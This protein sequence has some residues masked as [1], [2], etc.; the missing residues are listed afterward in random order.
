MSEQPIPDSPQPAPPESPFQ[1]SAIAQPSPTKP[2]LAEDLKRGWDWIV[3]AW[4]TL[5]RLGGPLEILTAFSTVVSILVKR[6]LVQWG[7][8]R[9][10]DDRL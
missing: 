8:V 6:T 9:D 7:W 3:F 10:Q 1:P 5:K 4:Q 2:S